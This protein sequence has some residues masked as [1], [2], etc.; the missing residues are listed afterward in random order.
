[1]PRGFIR[2]WQVARAEPCAQPHFDCEAGRDH[3]VYHDRFPE[4]AIGECQ[5]HRRVAA[6]C[7]HPACGRCRIKAV[8]LEQFSSP[9]DPEIVIPDQAQGSSPIGLR[10]RRALTGAFD[11]AGSILAIIAITDRA[12]K[13]R[14]G[15][16]A[17]HLATGTA[18]KGELAHCPLTMSTSPVWISR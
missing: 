8:R 9:C 18:R 15:N 16:L 7:D 2:P 10:N 11:I 12:Q 14:A 5:K 13:W 1:M 17:F 3:P 4:P 6:R